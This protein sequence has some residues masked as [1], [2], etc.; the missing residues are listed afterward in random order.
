LI[1][2]SAGLRNRTAT[3]EAQL[4]S[5]TGKSIYQGVHIG[6]WSETDVPAEFRLHVA[7]AAAIN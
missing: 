4:A 1:D 6:F 5:L 7:G 3:D 2:W